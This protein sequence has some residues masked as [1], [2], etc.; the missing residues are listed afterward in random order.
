MITE[1]EAL[2]QIEERLNYI[3]QNL[4]EKEL[5]KEDNKL[6][7]ENLKYAKKRIEQ[8]YDIQKRRN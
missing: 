7:F 6:A 2:N 1:K 3:A 5:K 4:T 8:Q